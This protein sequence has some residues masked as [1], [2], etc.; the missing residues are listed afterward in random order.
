M[1]E[2]EK[3][4]KILDK[5]GK[6]IADLE[7][8][9][10]SNPVSA[11]SG[12]RGIT[13]L[14]NSGFLDSYKKLGDILKELKIQAKFEKGVKYKKILEKLTREDKLTRKTVEHQWVY[15]RNG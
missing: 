2:I 6:K 12:E 3:I 10:K 15:K 13:A 8:L 4:K 1:S 9:I 5:H 7:K 11:I 14:M